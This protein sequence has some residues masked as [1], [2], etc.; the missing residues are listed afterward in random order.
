MTW[1]D[2]GLEWDFAGVETT[3]N[4]ALPAAERDP[5]RQDRLI[6]L[7]NIVFLLLAFMLLAGTFRAADTLSVEPPEARAS[8]TIDRESLMLY[9]DSSGNIAL[10]KDRMNVDEAISQVKIQLQEDPDGELHIKAD[11]SV[12]AAQI[13]PLLRKCADSEI[14]SI[15]LIAVRR[16]EKQ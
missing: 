10:G 13:L 15:R 12:T 2:E 5:D 11:R 16:G 8:G 3:G 1:Q 6:P 14:M 4:G 7:I 9:L